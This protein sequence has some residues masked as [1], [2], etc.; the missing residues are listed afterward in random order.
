MFV[1]R[2]TPIQRSKPIVAARSHRGEGAG[3]AIL[4]IL[5]GLGAIGGLAYIFFGLEL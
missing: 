5:S 4:F 2:R 1:T 3:E